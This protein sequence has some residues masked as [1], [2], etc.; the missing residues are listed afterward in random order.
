MAIRLLVADHQPLILFGIRGSLSAVDDMEIVG[1]ATSL[2]QLLPLVARTSPD[3]ILMDLDT[4]GQDALSTL[5]QLCFDYPQ[6]AVLAMSD[7]ND[8]TQIM[9][10]L[11]LGASGYILKNIDPG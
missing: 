8:P 5:E 6:V 1:E 10:A 2:Q 4:P 3:V 9:R 7:Q 11:E